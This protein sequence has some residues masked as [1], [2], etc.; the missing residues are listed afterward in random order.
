[1]RKGTIQKIE[2]EINEKRKMPKEV[3]ESLRKEIFTNIPS[4]VKT[5][6]MMSELVK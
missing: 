2:E 1:M 5:L 4:K 3:K 6:L